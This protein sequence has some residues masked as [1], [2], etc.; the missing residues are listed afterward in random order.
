MCC[1]PDIKGRKSLITWLEIEIKDLSSPIIKSTST[2]APKK[3]KP[4]PPPV[5]KMKVSTPGSYSMDQIRKLS[6]IGQLSTSDFPSQ[7]DDLSAFNFPSNNDE[8]SASYPPPKLTRSLP[9]TPPLT[10]SMSLPVTPSLP[11]T[12]PLRVMFRLLQVTMI[13]TVIKTTWAP[14]LG[15]RT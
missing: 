12:S 15:L 10:V 13:P 4:G 8:V 9:V 3:R 11:A 1:V 2:M 5:Y 7:N 6:T 14:N